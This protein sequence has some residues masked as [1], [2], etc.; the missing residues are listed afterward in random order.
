M[1]KRLIEYVT[2]S[3]R[4]G[5]SVP[6]HRIVQSE[7]F[8]NNMKAVKRIAGKIDQLKTKK[9]SEKLI[10]RFE[11]YVSKISYNK[12]EVYFKD[13]TCPEN[14]DEIMTFN[15]TQLS[16]EK[17]RNLREGETVYWDFYRQPDGSVIHQF[18]F[19]LP[20]YFT[21]REI[22]LAKKEA[23]KI[24]RYIEQTITENENANS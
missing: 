23:E 18:K 21:N 7:G 17:R 14:P 19:L 3:A 2:V 5:V 1:R 15:L 6:S 22:R 16:P 20:R 9:K 4:N 24:A 8:K 13:V 10:Q 12:F 11:G